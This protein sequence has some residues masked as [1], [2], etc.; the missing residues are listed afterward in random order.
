MVSLD[1]AAAAEDAAADAGAF[2][3]NEE[4]VPEHVGVLLE[5]QASLSEPDGIY[6]LLRSNALPVQLRLYEHEGAWG[7]ALAGFDM[8][9]RRRA[10]DAR[11]DSGPAGSR[12]KLM[13]VLR[14]MGCLHVLDVYVN[15]LPPEEA[16]TPQARAARFEAAWRVG[17]WDLPDAEHAR[18]DAAD[19][20]SATRALGLDRVSRRSDNA[21]DADDA[22]ARA[23]A[24]FH[25]DLHAALAALRAGDVASSS[26]RLD[27]IRGALVRRAT[28]E[29]V[30]AR[31][32]SRT[33]VIRLRMLD[34]VADA[35]KLWRAYRAPRLSGAN[36]S[37]GDASSAERV[38]AQ[39]ARSARET[40]R[41]RVGALAEQS[42]RIAEPLL[43]VHGVVLRELGDD[44]ALVAHLAETASLARKAGESAEGL[45]AIH[46]ARALAAARAEE[47]PLAP[48]RPSPCRCG[49]SRTTTTRAAS[50]GTRCPA[51]WRGGAWKRRSFCGPRAATRWPSASDGVSLRRRRPA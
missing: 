12:L 15:A 19:A 22:A 40:W 49:A 38:A 8:G 46:R 27:A 37:A 29:G 45:R 33:A 14:Q 31:E 5:A 4:R 28:T 43:A 16:A 11:G 7:Q 18:A 44:E 35:A 42:F 2:A 1:E 47:P 26:S 51:P 23:E 39:A 10:G 3:A 36:G 6:G 30:E 48:R 41:R 32:T 24:D 21:G 20:G 9:A 50:R 13:D 17:Q 34:D 25:R